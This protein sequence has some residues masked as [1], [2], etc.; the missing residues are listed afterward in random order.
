MI[1]A[2]ALAGEVDIFGRPIPV[3]TGRPTLVV[4]TNKG[5]ED[6]VQ[7]PL[8]DLLARETGVLPVVIVRVD[9]RGVPGLFHGIARDNMKS[10][11]GRGIERYRSQV[12]ALG[13]EAVPDPE[14]SLYFVADPNGAQEQAAGLPKGFTQPLGIAFDAGGHELVRVPFPTG[15]PSLLSA[16]ETMNGTR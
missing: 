11:W 8:P 13:R 5:T 10:R 7:D 14:N 2:T 12:R 3:N 16:L 9:L 1:A 4:Y 6:L 15:A